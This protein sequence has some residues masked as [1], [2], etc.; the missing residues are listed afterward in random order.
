MFPQ[1]LKPF[2]HLFL[3]LCKLDLVRCRWMR[4]KACGSSRPPRTQ[5]HWPPPWLSP[6]TQ[7]VSW[8]LSA[9]WEA[10]ESLCHNT[11]IGLRKNANEKITHLWL[12]PSYSVYSTVQ[13]MEKERKSP[14]C[15]PLTSQCK[16]VTESVCVH[17]DVLIQRRVVAKRKDDQKCK[18]LFVV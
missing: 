8:S 18:K 14:A 9:K 1:K 4:L 12:I 11:I 7:K 15:W 13:Q 16:T 10:A 2:L 6:L 3:I 5:C 17:L